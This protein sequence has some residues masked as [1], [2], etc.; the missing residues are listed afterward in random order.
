MKTNTSV[1][2]KVSRITGWIAGG[3]LLLAG[4]TVIYYET[5][6]GLILIV[7]SLILIPP[8]AAR[9]N[10]LMKF[11]LS[12][13]LKFVIVIAGLMIAG[14]MIEDTKPEDQQTIQNEA[15]D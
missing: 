14:S 10:R 2:E 12:G 7:L 4:I 15:A 1:L 8:L 6:A 11:R 5:A 13:W 3:I 9:V